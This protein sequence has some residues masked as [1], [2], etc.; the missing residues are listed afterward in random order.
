MSL[1]SGRSGT[2]WCLGFSGVGMKSAQWVGDRVWIRVRAVVGLA[3]GP[4]WSDKL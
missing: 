4:N 2:I 1:D 3:V